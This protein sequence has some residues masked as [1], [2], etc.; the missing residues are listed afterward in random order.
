MKIRNLLKFGFLILLPGA[1]LISAA[2]GPAA[3]GTSP[4]T[5]EIRTGVSTGTAITPKLTTISGEVTNF[6]GRLIPRLPKITPSK[7][8]TLP[9]GPGYT[10]KEGPSRLEN[11][12][13][14]ALTPQQADRLLNDAY[15]NCT[16]SGWSLAS[17]RSYLAAAQA[18]LRAYETAGLPAGNLRQLVSDITRDVKAL[19]AANP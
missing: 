7:I 12:L 1:S 14:P 5:F 8:T 13:G 11:E 9:P 4:G 3:G 10:L 6:N 17:Q 18:A 15:T 19:E 2:Q 16:K